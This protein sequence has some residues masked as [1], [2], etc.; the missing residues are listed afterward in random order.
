MKSKIKPYPHSQAEGNA[1]NCVS[2]H[3]GSRTKNCLSG[4]SANQSASLLADESNDTPILNSL[5]ESA[6]NGNA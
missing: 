6:L 3:I 5:L 2:S 4:Y 1:E